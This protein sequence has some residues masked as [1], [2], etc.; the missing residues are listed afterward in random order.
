MEHPAP[1]SEP[2]RAS[3]WRTSVHRDWICRLPDTVEHRIEQWRFG[4]AGIKPTVI[5]AINHGPSHLVDHCFV[6]GG[7]PTLTKPN[8]PLR[9]RTS[10]GQFKTSAAKEYPSR[11]CCSLIRATLAGLTHRLRQHGFV[12]HEALNGTEQAWIQLLYSAASTSSLSGQFLP[13]FH[14]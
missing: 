8:N 10:D 13:D 11:L 12:E 6:R 4:S 14:G 9:G 2:T 1:H 3:V 5:R 7:D